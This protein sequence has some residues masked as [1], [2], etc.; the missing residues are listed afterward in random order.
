MQTVDLTPTWRG[1]LPALL[2]LVENP[3]TRQDGLDEL[4]RM[5]NAADK[6]NELVSKVEYAKKRTDENDSQP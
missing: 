3:I 1:I 6:Y 4:A 2:A 5:A